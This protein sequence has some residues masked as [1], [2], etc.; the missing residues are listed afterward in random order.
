VDHTIQEEA[1]DGVAVKAASGPTAGQATRLRFER[2]VVEQGPRL[3]RLARRL[4]GNDE[5]AR[6][7]V[8]EGLLRAHRSLDGFRGEGQLE[9][10]V[11][12][13]VANQGLRR[14]RRR[15]LRQRLEGWLGR[16]RED[17]PDPLGWLPEGETPS[18]LLERR[19]AVR[20]L[21]QALATLSARQQQVVSLRYLEQMSVAQIAE[22]TGL[23]PGTVKT[24]LV[25]ALQ[26]L[27]GRLPEV[28][29]GE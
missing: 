24:H 5:D 7:V 18:E 27:R 20:D 26:A 23:G 22:V 12:R 21:R 29:G 9:A 6:E 25:R 14:L 13:I 11:M 4:V 19:Q 28:A 10:W 15:R 3:F 2:L 17:Q 8:Q 16:R 1:V